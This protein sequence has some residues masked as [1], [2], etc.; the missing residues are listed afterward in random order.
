MVSKGHNPREARP[1]MPRGWMA[2]V[3][4]LCGAMSSCGVRLG[5]ACGVL[6]AVSDVMG[7]VD[8]VGARRGVE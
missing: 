2:A 8:G 6:Y 7:V 3:K 5:E 4:G 1:V